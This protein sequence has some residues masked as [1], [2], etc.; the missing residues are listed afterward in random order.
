MFIELEVVEKK[1]N[2]T[3]VINTDQISHFEFG[4]N[5]RPH[6]GQ[7]SGRTIVH[8]SGSSSG[9]SMV[10]QME[11]SHLVDMSYSDFKKLVGVE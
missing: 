8:M 7:P 9:T 11:I 5:P 6:K 1:C 2:K 3:I 10:Q 4:S